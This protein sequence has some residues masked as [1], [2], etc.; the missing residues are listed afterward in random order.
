MSFFRRGGIEPPPADYHNLGPAEGTKTVQ[1]RSPQEVDAACKAEGIGPTDFAR[2][3]GKTTLGCYSPKSGTI[4]I[5]DQSQV[6]ADY[7]N[8]LY[9]HE[10]AHSRGLVHNDNGQGWKQ[11]PNVFAQNP[12]TFDWGNVFRGK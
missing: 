4:Y 8:E 5:I 9:D 11:A 12:L 3:G 2:I 6:P 10:S 1:L 7:W